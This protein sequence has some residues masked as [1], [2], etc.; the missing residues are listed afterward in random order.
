MIC[1]PRRKTSYLLACC[2]LFV[3]LN[4]GCTKLGPDYQEPDTE[5]LNSWQPFAQ[6]QLSEEA[7]LRFWYHI[8]NNHQ[9]NDLVAEARAQNIALEQ[10]GLRVLESRALLGIARSAYYPQ[11]QQ[12]SGSSTY[13][14]KEE[15]GANSGAGSPDYVAYSLGANIGW[16]FD[17]WGRFARAVEGADASYLRSIANQADAQV[18]LVAQVVDLYFS[19]QVLLHRIEIAKENARIQRRSFDITSSLYESGQEAEL[20][21]QQAKTQYLTTSAA[22]P[23]LE[24]SL[25]K[26]RNA[27]AVIVARPPQNL[28]WLETELLPLP[29]VDM[30]VAEVPAKFL[31]RR[32]DVRSAAYAVAAQSAQIGI[33]EADLYPTI[34]LLGSLS[35]TGNSLSSDTGLATFSLGPSFSWNVFDYGRIENS[36]RVEDARLQQTIEDYRDTV[37]GAAREV[38]DAIIDVVKTAKRQRIMT[39][40]LMAAKRSLELAQMRYREGYADFQRVLDAQRSLATQSENE[41][42]NRGNNLSAIIAL[43]KSLGGGWIGQDISQMVSEKSRESMEQ[44]TDW[45]ELLQGTPQQNLE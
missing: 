13:I 3:V 9:L 15:A 6:N 22:I 26:T 43:Y 33:A 17:F 2:L 21:V 4:T 37:L 28:P 14:N 42:V 23:V 11:V 16:E 39:E 8:F 20:N 34:S 38:E 35:F 32:P 19:H 44:R 31:L 40:S 5:W 1:S 41:L 10:A 45:G 24:A 27:L 30:A 36:V 7:D 29:V 18:L 25:I 12:I